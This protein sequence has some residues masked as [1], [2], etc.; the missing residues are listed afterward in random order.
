MFW[1]IL[2]LYFSKFIAIVDGGFN[3][4]SS[5]GEEMGYHSEAANI[6]S[7]RDR[8]HDNEDSSTEQKVGNDDNDRSNQ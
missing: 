1:I 6:S 3:L 2:I 4:F 5:E 7:H 8:L